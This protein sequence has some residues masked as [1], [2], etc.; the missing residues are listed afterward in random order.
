M[1]HK[2]N[3]HGPSRLIID[4]LVDGCTRLSSRCTR[5]LLFILGVSS[6]VFMLCTSDAQAADG[7]PPEDPVPAW[8]TSRPV[9]FL[10]P[11][12]ARSQAPF[13]AAPGG[14]EPLA[15]Q[16]GEAIKYHGGPVQTAPELYLLFWGNNFFN[17]TPPVTLYSQLKEFYY[18][19]GGEQDDP[20]ENSWQG[21]LT[22]YTNVQGSYTFAKVVGESR[23]DNIDAPKNLTLAEV[24][25]EITLWSDEG[26]HQNANTQV[27]VLTPPGTTFNSGYQHYCGYHDVDTQGY[28]YTLV[29]YNE[30]EC[31]IE[32]SPVHE[33]TGA[34]SHEFAESTTDPDTE[35][36]WFSESGEEVADLCEQYPA[37]E[38]PEKNGRQGFWWVVK[39]WDDEG[40]NKCSLEDPPYP[41]PPAPSVTTEAATG[42]VERGATLNGT[43]NPNGPYAHYHF[44]YGTTT[45]YGSSTPETDAGFG[46]TGV[47]V[48]AKISR[49]KPGTVY[50]YRL[51]ASSWVGT[52]DGEDHTLTTLP[53]WTIQTT[54]NPHGPLEIDGLYGVSCP[55]TT[56]CTAVGA[57]AGAEDQ[58]VTLAERWNGTSWEVQSTPNPSA[59]TGSFLESVSCTSSSECIA[60]GYYE[61]A[62][63]KH[64][65]LAESWDGSTWVVQKTPSKGDSA[66]LTSV[67][68]AS[69]TECAAVGFYTANAETEPL[70]ELWNGT[71]WKV[72]ASAK[73]PSEGEEGWFEGVSCPVMKACTAVGTYDG[74][75]LAEHALAETWNGSTWSVQATAEPENSLELQLRGVSCSAA[76]AC[77]ALGVYKNTAVDGETKNTELHAQEALVERWN[78][79]SWQ[80]QEPPNPE[81]RS[82]DKGGSHWG[83]SKVSCASA[84]ACM[85]VGSYASNESNYYGTLLGEDWNGTNWE[86]E[87]PIDRMGVE[88]DSLEGLSC[89]SEALCIA[90]GYSQKSRSAAETLAEKL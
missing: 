72:K 86:L 89:P 77:T 60:T 9:H 69:P 26:A 47:P 79:T 36:G 25:E 58:Y 4:N 1:V 66:D 76:N 3:N 80:L 83:L 17:N 14:I 56:A 53:T 27:I 41:P 31:D 88:W 37:E 63:G 44:E 81:G 33:T 42:V 34:A 54:V 23:I 5:A 61:N 22:Q 71:A 6:C 21:I 15:G 45:S 29:P 35:N 67:S 85:A 87:S 10:P 68:C 28:S 46:T 48:S 11:A 40:G 75:A 38:L 65:T 32:A 24:L 52:T 8:A 12:S 2:H 59:A 13:G 90:V 7:L 70:V 49:L 50:H 57:Y 19:L 84:T 20:G 43:V 18:G 74:A 82:K 73:L 55:S 64:F 30:A 39:L 78:G 62:K 16:N 51:V